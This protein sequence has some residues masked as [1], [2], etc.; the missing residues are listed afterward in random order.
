MRDWISG[1]VRRAALLRRLLAPDSGLLGQGVRY[2]LVGGTAALVYLLATTLL[3]LVVGL[4]FQLALTIGF[5]L[6]MAFHFTMQRVFVWANRDGFA[7]PLHHQAGRYL[8]VAAAQYAATSLAT[9]LLP[10]ALGLST[11]IVYLATV[12][13]LTAFNFMV[14]RHGVFHANVRV[15]HSE[16]EACEA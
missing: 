7:L 15:A 1:N 8:S 10:G 2:A 11:E 14:F 4:P 12:V 3:A 9:S 16:G 6:S 13:L 5:L